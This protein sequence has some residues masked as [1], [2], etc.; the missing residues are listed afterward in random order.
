MKSLKTYICLVLAGCFTLTACQSFKDV[1]DLKEITPLSAKFEI[2]LVLEMVSDLSGLKLTMIN[3]KEGWRTE[4]TLTG[5]SIQIDDIVPGFYTVQVAGQKTGIDNVVYTLNGSTRCE[6]LE[7]GGVINL[8]VDG[9]Q[10]SP[11]IFK[12]IFYN[13]VRY[14]NAAGS[15]TQYIFSQ[16]YEIYNN[17]EETAYIDGLYI[18][19]IAPLTA[20]ASNTGGYAS[21]FSPDVRKV[22]GLD[23]NIYAE[24]VWQFPG[25][26]TDYPLEPGES[27]IVTMRAMDH[28]QVGPELLDLRTAE[29]EFWMPRSGSQYD[30][31]A[32]NMIH[33]YL[34]DS[35]D[36][37]TLNQYLVTVA[38]PAIVLFNAPDD[39]NPL[40]NQT[41]YIHPTNPNNN[42]YYSVIPIGWVMDAVECGEDE[43]VIGYKRIPAV[44][45]GGMMYVGPGNSGI[46]IT[47][48]ILTDEAGEPVL[49]PNGDYMY[50]DTNN[51]YNDFEATTELMIRRHG[52][53]MPA[54][55]HSLQ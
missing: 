55:N 30:F 23:A 45:D 15:K 7:S 33:R 25:T 27:C 6:L 42:R 53:R 34:N 39:Y 31:D 12:E 24:R 9:M 46:T 50:L 18:S 5:N 48:K 43:T 16:F 35:S 36:P 17:S 11:L 51:S 19:N 47:R 38:G 20:T 8:N 4:N 14:T 44:L 13:N 2:N 49:G 21:T 37:G 22:N 29:F 3:E 52:A 41:E 26:G 1:S 32:P 28:T 40:A 54:W 10:Y